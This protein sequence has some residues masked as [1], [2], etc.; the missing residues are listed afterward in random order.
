MVAKQ[1]W[2]FTKKRAMAQLLGPPMRFAE[3]R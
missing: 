2:R 3:E 1:E